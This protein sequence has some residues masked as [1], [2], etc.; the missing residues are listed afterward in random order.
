MITNTLKPEQTGW[1]FAE[2]IFLHDHP[3]ILIKI[4]WK[5]ATEA[6]VDKSALIQ[7]MVWCSEAKANAGIL[8][9]EVHDAIWHLQTPMT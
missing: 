8:L 1:H 9:I 6:P 7:V 5:F 4:S 3:G 2:A